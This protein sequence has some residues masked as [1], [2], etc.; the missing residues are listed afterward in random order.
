MADSIYYYKRGEF[1]Q[2]LKTITDQPILVSDALAGFRENKCLPKR[3][4]ELIV[5]QASDDPKLIAEIHQALRD[6][7]QPESKYK[8]PYDKEERQK[9]I[10]DSIAESYDIDRK[11]TQCK[12]VTGY[13]KDDKTGQQFPYAVE[14]AIAPRKDLDVDNAGEVTFIGSV[15]DTPAIDGGERYFQSDQYAYTWTDRRR[16][17]HK[18]TAKDVLAEFGFNTYWGTSRRRVP[19]V[20]TINIKTNVPDWLG[21]AGKTHINQ[22]PYGETI[23]KAL[24]SISRNIPSYRGQGY[25]AVYESSSSSGQKSMEEYRADFLKEG[26]RQIETVP[27]LRETDRLTQRGAWYRVRPRMVEDGFIPRKN[28]GTTG[29]S[30]ADG[31]RD[32]CKELWPDENITREYLGIYAKARGMFYFKGHKYPIEYESIDD[33][34]SKAPVCS[35][36]EKDGVPSVLEPYADKY[37]VALVSTQGNFV[38]YVKDFVRAAMEENESVVVTLLDDDKVGHDMAKSTGA[39]NI[40]VCEETVSWLQKN[41]YP[42]IRLEDVQE[43]YSP[44]GHTTEYRIEID[45]ILAE[46]GAEGLWKY[47]MHKVEELKPFDLT[48]SVDMPANEVLYP[49]KVSEF[50]SFLN[51]YTDDV[52]KTKRDEIEYDLSHASKL[53]DVKE[54]GKEID[55]TLTNIVAEDEGMELIVS[56]LVEVRSELRKLD[57]GDK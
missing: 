32:A 48:K 16:D 21:A 49:E 12:V 38:D 17:H 47:I 14:I 3:L 30:F 15:N 50:L 20:V 41:G 40:G 11:N 43:K 33:L 57:G 9:E 1:K 44:D 8:L 24:S 37:G 39:I 53:C 22:I 29:K 56:K 23:A 46:V 25:A 42:D 31:I 18:T 35:V 27:S 4:G 36:I 7:M 10:V 51:E 54:M 6:G 45:A 52:T 13:Y 5:Q 26:R 2:Y 28:W 34:A 55:E 19:S